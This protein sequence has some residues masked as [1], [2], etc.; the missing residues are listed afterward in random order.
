MKN[1]ILCFVK[2]TFITLGGV[3]VFC[4]SLLAWLI[5]SG[6]SPSVPV[7]SNAYLSLVVS[8]NIQEFHEEDSLSRIF[9]PQKHSLHHMVKALK[10]AASDDRMK[11]VVL[12]LDHHDLGLGKIETLREA[13]KA[14][15]ATGK[16]VYAY[17]DSFGE[18]SGATKDYFLSAV[19]DEIWLQNFG[20]VNLSGLGI[21][22]PFFK[23]LLDHAGVRANIYRRHEYKGAPE[24]L[25]GEHP[26]PQYRQEWI[27]LLEGMMRGIKASIC[28]DRRM[29]AG[30][31]NK[32]LQMGSLTDEE[33][34]KMGFVDRASSL[35]ALGQKIREEFGADCEGISYLD[36]LEH[37]D[38]VL[39]PGTA[40][41]AVLYMSGD[42]EKDEGESEANHE[43]SAIR[44]TRMERAIRKIA[45][46][47]NVQALVIR[48]DSPGGSV[49]ASET[50]FQALDYCKQKG[51]KVVASLSDIAASGGYWLAMAGDVIVAHPLTITGSIGVYGGKFDIENLSKIL[52][53]HWEELATHEN[54]LDSSIAKPFSE[55]ALKRLN[56][57]LDLTY[58]RFTERVMQLRG[59]SAL[60]V[61]RVARGRVWTGEQALANGLVD[62]LGGLDVAIDRAH[63]LV[64]GDQG[65]PL[66][67]IYY[68]R[69][70][71]MSE[72]LSDA[73]WGRENGFEPLVRSLVRAAVACVWG[74]IKSRVLQQLRS[75]GLVGELQM[76]TGSLVIH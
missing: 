18:G 30:Q 27:S 33:A 40:H 42:I 46:N 28:A 53:I 51:K 7:A 55:L 66:P 35:G 69:L 59:L 9:D 2:A 52:G 65:A 73:I 34:V 41:I 22:V 25:T 3:F 17:T 39:D 60:E 76:R 37:F 1:K 48:I 56:R 43:T 50:I 16:K 45:D 70:K 58:K 71:K 47:P 24:P 21:S 11:A 4:L 36:Y 19:A 6:S 64:S 26:S 38:E 49:V 13:L 75:R 23:K 72:M 5:F 44:S 12:K 54:A 62:H 29:D 61:D 15:K 67:V 20:E 10:E 74:D 8:G 14:F 68:P 31:L 63:Q 32:A 57:S